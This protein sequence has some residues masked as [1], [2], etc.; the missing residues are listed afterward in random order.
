VQT[1][2]EGFIKTVTPVHQTRPVKGYFDPR[3]PQRVSFSDKGKGQVHVMMSS[4]FLGFG[5]RKVELPIISGNSLRGVLRRNC[6]K[7]LLDAINQ[8]IRTEL[9]QCLVAGASARDRV[10]SG[11]TALLLQ[12]ARSHVFAGVF[13]GGALMLNSCYSVADMVP[14]HESIAHLMSP[15]I[16]DSAPA[17][18]ATGDGG[19][20]VPLTNIYLT[21][22]RDPFL[23]GEGVSYVHEHDKEFLSYQSELLDFA[24]RKEEA[25]ASDGEGTRGLRMISYVE[26]LVPGVPLNFSLTMKHYTNDAQIGLMLLGLRQWANAQAIGGAG[27][28]G[29]GRFQP[30]LRLYQDSLDAPVSL[31]QPIGDGTVDTYALNPA[32]QR[33][34]DAAQDAIAR[35]TVTELEELFIGAAAAPVKRGRKVL[36]ASAV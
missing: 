19:A 28:R 10:G 20:E 3:N 12:R 26:A 16:V 23:D 21:V 14:V 18:P 25:A 15:W 5:N 35:V 31:F 11:Q 34:V 6:A 32:V 4:A 22:R 30:A 2:I 36:A 24:R 7:V 27:R 29:F 9:F 1:R 13:G 33:Y 8:P 17:I